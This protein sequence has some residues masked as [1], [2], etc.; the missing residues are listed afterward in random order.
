[1]SGPIFF[2]IFLTVLAIAGA[3]GLTAD[4]REGGEWSPTEDGRRRAQL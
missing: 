4:S 1:M 2:A 3:F